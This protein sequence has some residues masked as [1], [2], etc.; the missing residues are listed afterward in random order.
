MLQTAA[1]TQL[2]EI[3]VTDKDFERLRAVI[4][5]Y[6]ASELAEFADALEAELER[7]HVVPQR[8]VTGDVMTM[9]SRAIVENLQTGSQRELELVYPHEAD[10][11]AGKVSTLAPAGLAL[12]GLRAGETIRWPMAKGRTTRLKVVE[13]RYQPELAGELD[14]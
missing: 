6:A 5:E 4:G 1:Q 2:P 8:E 14:R 9:R 13:V 10:P 7:A 3:F 11:T 12:L